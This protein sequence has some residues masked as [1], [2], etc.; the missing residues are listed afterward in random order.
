MNI[1]ENY[2]IRKAS[3]GQTDD[4]HN[5]IEEGDIDLLRKARFYMLFTPT[6]TLGVCYLGYRLKDQVLMSR[7]FYYIIKKMQEK[8]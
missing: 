7:H 1:I 2:Y 6:V 4:L 8:F 3:M 5:R